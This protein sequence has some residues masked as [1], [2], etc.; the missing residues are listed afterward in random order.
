MPVKRQC[1]HDSEKI[2]EIKYY[3]KLTVLLM[4]YAG[5][6]NIVPC[7]SGLMNVSTG[8]GVNGII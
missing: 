3:M 7:N 2:A 8:Q 6:Y 5:E 1:S 4:C